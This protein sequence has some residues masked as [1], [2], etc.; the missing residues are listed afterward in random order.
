M[1][2]S[3]EKTALI[4][5]TSLVLFSC[6]TSSSPD[7]PKVNPF[8]AFQNATLEDYELLQRDSALNKLEIVFSANLQGETEPCGC[9]SGPKGGLDRRLNYLRMTPSLG[10]RLVLDAGNSLF[11]T[12]SLDPAQK[13]QLMNRARLILEASRPMGFRAINLGYLDFSAGVDFIRAEARKW[14]VP[15]VSASFQDAETGKTPW[16]RE[17]IDVQLGSLNV[18]ITGLSA[19]RNGLEGLSFRPADEAFKS[20]I[21]QPGDVD[22]YVLL[23]DLGRTADQEIMRTHSKVPMVI[24]GSRDL[25]SLDRPTV[26]G[27]EILVQPA[28]RGQQWGVL[29]VLFDRQGA[30]WF[31]LGHSRAFYS[32]WEGLLRSRAHVLESAK[33]SEKREELALQ[34]AAAKELLEQ[35]PAGAGEKKHAFTYDLIDL[36]GR[37]MKTNELSAKMKKLNGQ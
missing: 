9:A 8:A 35:A 2:G 19:G 23:S 32:R 14:K 30:G 7:W 10:D 3:V 25:S 28:F 5:F 22:L 15:F 16:F 33:G 18:R 12:E 36:G 31:N 29:R 20:V 24:I 27:K 11:A 6:A 17:F 4:A 26:L 37:Y 34:D 21:S 13:T 1:E